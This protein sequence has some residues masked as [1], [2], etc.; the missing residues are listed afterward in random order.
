MFIGR[1][2][3][4]NFLNERYQSPNAELIVLY[5]R[6]RVGKTELIKEFCKDKK[7]IFYLCNE[8]TNN[9]QLTNFSKKILGYNTN[10]LISD[11]FSDWERAF[12]YLGELNSDEKIVIVID[13]FPYMVKGD[14]SIPSI[15]QGVWDHNLMHKNI[16]LIL[17]GSSMSFFENEILGYKNPLY[18]RSTGIYKLEPLEYTDAVKFFPNY[19]NEDKLIA[20]AIL[21]GIPHYLKQFN[22]NESLEDNI[23]KRVLTK[24]TILFGEV[25]YLI[26]QE[27]R[28]PAVY[29]SIIEAIAAG[30]NTFSKIIDHSKIDSQKITVYLKNLTELGIIKK[31]FSTS[32]TTKDKV[33]NSKG[34]YIICD[35]LFSFYYK[36]IFHYMGEYEL[37]K[38][39]IL[40][41]ALIK[42]DL[43]HFSSKAFENVCIGYLYNLA[44]KGELPGAFINFGRWW[45]KT[46]HKTT[47]GKLITT[48]EEIDILGVDITKKKYILGECK[49]RNSEFT[50]SQYDDLTKKINLPGNIYYY[51][52]SLNGFSSS[53]VEFANNNSNIK[54]ITLDNIFE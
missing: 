46:T 33:N 11:S 7:H 28:E 44:S 23:I 6:R 20:Y 37:A 42:N 52:F 47:E 25:D 54:L 5:G 36:Y 38:S 53:L 27:L 41:N 21:G 51:L 34:E 26:H 12:N 31:E 2:S 35:N 40:W 16:M 48:P 32:A 49:F 15:L 29:N 22:P 8:Y 4:I 45:G 30:C 39:N 24:G 19:S 14:K 17:S 43:H 13:E 1:E 18:G 3:E 9:V 50:F 10:N